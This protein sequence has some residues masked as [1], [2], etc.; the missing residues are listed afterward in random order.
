MKALKLFLMTKLFLSCFAYANTQNP[1]NCS[2]FK[3]VSDREMTTH[4]QHA[5]QKVA[6]ALNQ[7]GTTPAPIA[8]GRSSKEAR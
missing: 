8:P 1:Q 2:A 7:E 4:P 6:H 3:P 5:L